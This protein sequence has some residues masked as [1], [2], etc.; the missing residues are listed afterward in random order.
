M[1][2]C[3]SHTVCLLLDRVYVSFHWVSIGSHRMCNKF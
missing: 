2:I 3:E 1:S